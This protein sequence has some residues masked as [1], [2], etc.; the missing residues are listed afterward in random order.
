VSITDLLDLAAVLLFVVGLVGGLFPFVGFWALCW[1]AVAL[2]A[3]S[4]IIST[5]QGDG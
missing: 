2:V 3:I 1:G 5:R 4:Y